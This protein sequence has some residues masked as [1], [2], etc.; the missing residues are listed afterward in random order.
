MTSFFPKK[1]WLIYKNRFEGKF[2]LGAF[3]VFIMN[4]DNMENY[5][6]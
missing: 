4:F 3:I 1:L 5:F 6:F 2:T